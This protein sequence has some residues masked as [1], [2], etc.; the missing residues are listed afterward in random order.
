MK[1][2]HKS[3]RHFQTANKLQEEEEHDDQKQK[4]REFNAVSTGGEN[5]GR[6]TGPQA[7]S[8]DLGE[9]RSFYTPGRGGNNEAQVRQSRWRKPGQSGR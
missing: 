3:R 1:T 5:P 9:E 2:K 6:L 8:D 7:P 4:V